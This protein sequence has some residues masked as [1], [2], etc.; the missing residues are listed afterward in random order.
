MK[1]MRFYGILLVSSSW[2]ALTGGE[3]VFPGKEGDGSSQAGGRGLIFLKT[4]KTGGSTVA[5]LLHRFSR[6]RNASCFVP[7][8]KYDAHR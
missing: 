8:E 1:L 7:P 2:C 6:L 3:G 4:H 5:T